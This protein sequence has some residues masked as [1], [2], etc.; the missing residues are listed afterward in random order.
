MSS[1]SMAVLALLCTSALAQ[2][3]QAATGP[4]AK[5]A[6]PA[7]ASAAEAHTA[8]APAD[9]TQA[10]DTSGEDYTATMPTVHVV[11][12]AETS[13]TKGYIGYEEADV[14]RNQLSVKEVPQTVDVLDIQKNKNYGT[15]D[16][17][18]I[19]EGNA[20]IDA[21]Y[22]MRGES[23]FIRGFQADGSDI[24]RDGVRESGQVRRSTANIERVEILKGPS[25][26]LY[27]RSAGGGVINMV[28]KFANF[29]PRRS[30]GL[31]YGSWANRSATFDINQVIN[32]GVA[33]RLTGEVA[34][35][36]SWR[37]TVHTKGYMLSPSI[38]VRAGRL[39]WTG[40]YT[41]DSARRVPDRT[42]TRDVYEAM[43]ISFRQGFARPGDFVRDDLRVLRSDL[44][45]AL[46]NQWDLRWQLARR[47]ASQNF[48]H[49]FG[50]AYNATRRL[51]YQSYSW[52]ETSNKTLSSALTLNGRVKTGA[53]EHKLS[54]GLDLAREER[55]PTLATLRNQPIDPFAA[56][57][58]WPRVH[59]RPAAT[60]ANRHR[61]PS[62]GLFVQDLIALRPDL[63]A[64]L[65][66]RYDRYKFRST[67]IR[68][69]SA[70]YS[71]SSFSPNLGV[72]WDI[73]PEHTAYASWNKSF[74]PY[75]GRGNLGV[76]IADSATFNADPEESRQ[77]EVGLKSEWLDRQL[78]TTLS[79]YN[80]EHRNIRYRPDPDDLTRWAV[81]GKERSRGIELSAI[82]RLHP[83]WYVRGS[84]GLMSAKILEDRATPARVG[85]SLNNTARV[86]S[87]LF[88]RYAPRPWYAEVGVTHLG[89]RHYWS[90]QGV[91]QHLPGFTR[92]DAMLGFNRA[93]WT[94][95]AAVQNVFNKQYWRS[96]AMPGSPRAVMVKASYEF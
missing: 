29:T 5:Q 95:T 41:W 78:S 25:S 14:T 73:T 53:L 59:P 51:L 83:Q 34:K 27:G 37:S 87:N 4:Q 40:Q 50:G 20:G 48:D 72:V 45:Y 93:S 65:G 30:V 7:A 90:N 76:D 43:G 64:L 81:R 12:T 18:S 36:N 79:L 22:D 62:L 80:L 85:R 74:A 82:G 91:E 55:N 39:A 56:P 60:L 88:V 26:V 19:L 46:G 35:A 9:T 49:Y 68:G 32:P 6:Q 67:N 38:T 84:L 8:Q 3:G 13:V 54:L 10:A 23:I 33:V 75:G 66:G 1:I 86:S 57:S 58:T 21:T 52:Q 63:K 28:S 15:N 2:T 44:S 11:G 16:L 89:K 47:S 24:Y 94:F 69:Q 70:A 42:P 77:I 96:S 61:A 17:S 92:V 31:A 71:G